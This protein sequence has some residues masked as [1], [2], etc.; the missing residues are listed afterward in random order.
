MEV[1]GLA[2]LLLDYRAF[3]VN[4]AGFR[5]AEPLSAGAVLG[6]FSIFDSRMEWNRLNLRTF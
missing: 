1:S 4:R 3:L 6:V 5:V 2:R